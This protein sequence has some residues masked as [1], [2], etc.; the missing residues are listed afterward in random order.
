MKTGGSQPR[1]LS[2]KKKSARRREHEEEH[3]WD[4]EDEEDP[5]VEPLCG[6]HT[7]RPVAQQTQLKN[8]RQSSGVLVGRESVPSKSLNPGCFSSLLRVMM[9]SAPNRKATRI[10]SSAARAVLQTSFLQSTRL[11]EVLF[12]GKEEAPVARLS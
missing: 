1:H 10:R 9:E 6:C 7:G 12:N 2:V 8:L 11:V 3:S 5:D 4:E